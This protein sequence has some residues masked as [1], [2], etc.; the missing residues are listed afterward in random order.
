MPLIKE[1]EWDKV[2]LKGLVYKLFEGEHWVPQIYICIY[3]LSCLWLYMT[4]VTWQNVI[5]H[6]NERIQEIWRKSRSVKCNMKSLK[7][8]TDVK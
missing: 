8:S 5:S 7:L 3:L 1:K 6:Y 4:Q 2:L